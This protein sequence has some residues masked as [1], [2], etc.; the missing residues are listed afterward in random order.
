MLLGADSLYRDIQSKI[1]LAWLECQNTAIET[2][3][4]A[5]SDWLKLSVDLAYLQPNLIL[6]HYIA[7]IQDN[8]SCQRLQVS[9]I[10]KVIA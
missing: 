5:N 9:A 10:F 8:A 4:S 1:L 7:I 2:G 3:S 6:T